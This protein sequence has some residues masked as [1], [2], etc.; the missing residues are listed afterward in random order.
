MYYHTLTPNL[1]HVLLYPQGREYVLVS[2]NELDFQ[3]MEK[4]Q[5]GGKL[6]Y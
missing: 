6:S 4:V 3:A 2:K 1:A 5:F